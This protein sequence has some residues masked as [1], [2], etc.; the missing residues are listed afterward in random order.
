MARH[1]AYGLPVIAAQQRDA[2]PLDRGEAREIRI[3]HD[4]VRVL[5]MAGVVDGVADVAQVRRGFEQ[6]SFLGRAFVQRRER[7]EQLARKARHVPRMA[8]VHAETPRELFHQGAL[9]AVEPRPLLAHAAQRQVADDA[10]AD[11]RRAVGKLRDLELLEH[12]QQHRRA[13]Q[14]D[15]GA[16]GADA[17]QLPPRRQ[18]HRA[19]CL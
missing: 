8:Q 14:N 13:G 7:V 3:G 2:F 10:V 6:A 5:V 9:L 12:T 18:V 17:G 11:A 4:V 16:P 19:N 1:A 15:L